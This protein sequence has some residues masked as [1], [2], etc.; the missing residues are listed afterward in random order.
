MKL[1]LVGSS[2]S[3]FSLAAAAQQSL[4]C[5]LESL[6]GSPEGKAKFVLRGRPG[7]SLFKDCTAISASANA[8]RGLWSGG[9][10][11]FV[12]SGTKFFEVNSSGT[13]VGATSTI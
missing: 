9:G 7:I 1:P 10:R 11:L 2:N 12:A 6:E 13:L 5:Y 3:A 4:N 8:T